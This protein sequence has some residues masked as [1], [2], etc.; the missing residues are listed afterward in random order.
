VGISEF[1]WE[2]G[3][4]AG[5]RCPRRG[6]ITKRTQ[7]IGVSRNSSHGIERGQ[8][9]CLIRKSCVRPL[10]STAAA[11]R[12]HIVTV[13][14]KNGALHH[15][16]LCLF[17]LLSDV[18]QPRAIQRLWRRGA[19]CR[20]ASRRLAAAQTAVTQQFWRGG[21]GYAALA[22]RAYRPGPGRQD[23][24]SWVALRRSPLVHVQT[25]RP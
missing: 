23:G 8:R 18:C 16:L 21:G 24:G 17:A 5:L 15:S 14:R 4:A 20:D 22:M 2:S 3:W 13:K 19:E 12:W 7:G 10:A 6:S 11:D 25:I 1:G 9:S